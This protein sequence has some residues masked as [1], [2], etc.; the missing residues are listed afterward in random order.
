[1]TAKSSDRTTCTER[2]VF[3]ESTDGYTLAGALFE[4]AG[5]KK[6]STLVIWVHG[7]HLR[8]CEPEYVEIGRQVA[9][10]K[11]A[12]LSMNT[13]GQDF[14]VWMRGRSEA[15]LA[16]SGWELMHE[17]T[18]D[19]DG[20]LRFAASEG[21][22][23]LVLAGHGFGGSKIIY[24]LSE[25]HEPA[26][27]GVVLVS[28][29]SIVRDMVKPEFHARAEAMVAEGHGMDLLPWGTRPGV[30]SSTVSAQVLVARERLHR[31]L[32]GDG[33]R[34]PALTKIRVPVLAWFGEDEVKL[35]RDVNG[36][37]ESM[38]QNL[39]SSPLVSTKVLPGT[40]YLCTGSEEMIA[41]EVLEWVG[42]LRHR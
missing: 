23:N 27:R 36:L 25:R 30:V 12:F 39:T 41:R 3:T 29:A 33:Q 38:A 1:M 20:W 32:Y 40:T 35:G 34:P 26:V 11:V 4:P 16:G 21:Y 19:L 17:C 14:G 8:F 6:A 10:Q 5:R 28:C 24:H 37:L 7:I 13:R 9:S 31:D 22:A 18:A 2:L 15:K 42:R